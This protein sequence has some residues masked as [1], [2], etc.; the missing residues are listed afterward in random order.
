MWWVVGIVACSRPDPALVAQREATALAE[1]AEARLVAGDPAGAR[2]GFAAARG[3]HDAPL[4]QAW[5]GVAAARAGKLAEAVDLAGDALS[6]APTLAAARYNRAAWLVQL[7]REDEAGPELERAL[8]DGA[9]DA[10]DVLD[11]PD[12]AGV[13]DHPAF[14][15]LPEVGLVASI[16]PPD[17]VAFLGSELTVQLRVEGIVPDLTVSAAVLQG[18]LELV[19]VE[20]A[21]VS[22]RRVD[23][24]WTYRVVGAGPIEMGPFTI[25]AGTRTTSGS[26]ISV[27]ADA[28]PGH[29]APSSSP[30]L[31]VPS[32]LPDGRAWIEGTRQ[33]V[34]TGPLDRVT[35]PQP[36][37][38]LIREGD[39]VTSVVHAGPA[40]SSP[41][42]V[43]VREADGTEKWRGTPERG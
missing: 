28:P 26:A 5:E 11:D 36:V 8:A 13:L 42:E 38:L 14:Q 30:W 29:A 10:L 31:P 16:T 43:V 25:G 18:P 24:A 32:A 40:P 35:P 20:E 2:A 3:K 21:R 27:K 15:F 12:F 23:V 19:R 33:F 6:R 9:A 7:G 1:A 34:R 39:V 4:L 41:T 22:A 17:P 37:R